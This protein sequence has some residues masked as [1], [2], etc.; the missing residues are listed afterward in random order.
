MLKTMGFDRTFGLLVVGWESVPGQERV[1][2][3]RP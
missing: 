1:T 2:I 3:G